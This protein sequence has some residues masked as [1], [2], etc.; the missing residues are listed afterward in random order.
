MVKMPLDLRAELGE[1]IRARRIAQGWSQ[2]DAAMRAGLG[3]ST[4]K[5]METKGPGTV[6][7]LISA[8]IALSC[9]EG[10]ARLFPNPAAPSLDAP[11]ERQVAAA[12]PRQRVSR[13]RS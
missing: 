6:E 2:V 8:A 1:A 10:I 5:R 3:L 7:N 13:P 9:E 12:K 4:W 11:S